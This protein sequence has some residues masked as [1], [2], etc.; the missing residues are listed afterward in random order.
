MTR[1]IF[2]NAALAR[3]STPEQLD[4][5]IKVTSPAAW[6]ALLTLAVLVVAAIVWSAICTVPEKVTGKGI[7]ISPGG[8]REVV[9][10]TQGRVA[11]FLVQPGE[12]VE[13]GRIVAHIAQPDIEN[14]LNVARA[15]V[16]EAN[17]QY[18]K[19]LDLQQRD[20]AS[21]KSYLTQKRQVLT[22]QME[23][24]DDRLKWLRER[25]SIEADLKSKGLIQR[26]RVIDTKIE[27]NAAREEYERAQNDM[28][29]IDLD[30]TTLATTQEKQRIDQQARIASLERK[31][32]T[33]TEQLKR[34]TD[35][36][37]PYSGYIVE[38]KVNPGEVIEPGRTLFSMLPH[39]RTADG[40]LSARQS[41][42]LVATLYVKPEDG[43]KI[44]VGM[45]AQIS[46][47]T[48]KHEEFGFIEGRVISV[49]SIPSTQEGIERTLKNRQ[50][51]QELSGGGAPFEVSVAL[52]PDAGS[53][54]GFKWSSS[55]GPDMEINPGTVSRGTITVRQVHLISLVIPALE[56]LFARY[57]L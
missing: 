49:A 42:D 6:L 48:V 8:V 34:N 41:G 36:T 19:L 32:E 51:V 3:L 57:H 52:T 15:E 29:Q 4:Q 17:A 27:I 25:E 55:A 44:H 53:R 11:S 54:D 50:L 14:Q 22:Q 18:E 30:E 24:A 23:F 35:L 2:R 26:Q 56:P 39:E 33:L 31:V 38:F 43:K 45:P 5:A 10:S 28:K 1:Q 7:L 37:S 12:W 16:I 20:V 9:S 40:S 13:S 47:S 46:P 21:Q